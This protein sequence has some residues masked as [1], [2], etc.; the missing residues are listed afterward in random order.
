MKWRAFL[1]VASDI[2]PIISFICPVYLV[3]RVYARSETWQD[4]W[5]YFTTFS[6][7]NFLLLYPFLLSWLFTIYRSIVYILYGQFN[8]RLLEFTSSFANE[9]VLLLFFF[10]F[11]TYG[12][13]PS[14]LWWI[15]VTLFVML[16]SEVSVFRNNFFEQPNTLSKRHLR[17]FLAFEVFVTIACVILMSVLFYKSSNDM[18]LFVLFY[19]VLYSFCTSITSLACHIILTSEFLQHVDVPRRCFR[20][21]VFMFA[22]ETFVSLLCIIHM[23]TTWQATALVITSGLYLL[24]RLLM[25]EHEYNLF[26][27]AEEARKPLESLPNASTIDLIEHDCCIVCRQRM[28]PALSK[29]LPC[30]HC[31]HLSCLVKWMDHQ[32][33]CPLCQASMSTMMK[34]SDE[35]YFHEYRNVLELYWKLGKRRSRKST[36]YLEPFDVFRFLLRNLTNLKKEKVFLETQHSLLLQVPGVSDEEIEQNSALIARCDDLIVEHD[37]AI[38]HLQT[39]I[40]SI[41][42]KKC[43]GMS[44]KDCVDGV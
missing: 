35:P 31:M 29:R 34:Y 9:L 30:H 16:L 17:K 20:V 23:V 2:Y 15:P 11:N 28:T 38:Y 21:Q 14:T 22:V 1:C 39:L 18:M 27:N 25:Y 12:F 40:D 13:S 6:W 44:G 3:T 37:T 43:L 10:I 5:E 41:T 8:P 4:L 19:G 7:R 36:R 32:R 26:K 42:K 33:K 24:M